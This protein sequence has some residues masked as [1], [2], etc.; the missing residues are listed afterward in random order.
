MIG[1][2]RKK[3]GKE[4]VKS[5]VFFILLLLACFAFVSLHCALGMICPFFCFPHLKIWQYVEGGIK[6]NKKHSIPLDIMPPEGSLLRSDGVINS[7]QDLVCHACSNII[8]SDQTSK[9]D[10]Q[11][12]KG[13]GRFFRDHQRHGFEIVFKEQARDSLVLVEGSAI[14]T[15]RVL[16]R[17]QLLV[18]AIY[19]S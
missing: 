8:P 5:D 18:R 6:E 12:S 3:N 19:Y 16:V 7:T 11:V 17:Q 1:K 10:Q 14:F 2:K 4:K 15:D 9:S 13:H